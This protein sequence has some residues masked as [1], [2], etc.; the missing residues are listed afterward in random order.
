M[1]DIKKAYEL[2]IEAQKL[3]MDWEQ[4][5]PDFTDQDDNRK[6]YAAN[7]FLDKALRALFDIIS[8]E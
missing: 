3:L 2:M 6:Y 8:M 5:V 7:D 4:P 1:K